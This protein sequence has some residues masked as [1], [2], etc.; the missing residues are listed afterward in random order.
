[1]P[2][3]DQESQTLAPDQ[4]HH[5]D[6]PTP[7]SPRH[8]DN[9]TPHSPRH[10]SDSITQ[11]STQS[12]PTAQQSH[13]LYVSQSVFDQLSQSKEEPSKFPSIVPGHVANA[14]TF[15]E[16]GEIPLFPWCSLLFRQICTIMI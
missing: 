10:D 7:H 12:N 3:H 4:S 5:E 8:E 9:P 11:Q 16:Y 15:R 2:E 1:M 14:F 6:N 13:P